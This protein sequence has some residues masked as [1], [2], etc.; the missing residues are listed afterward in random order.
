MAGLLNLST[1]S[2]PELLEQCLASLYHLENSENLTK[3]IILQTGN[4]QVSKLVDSFL[5]SRTQVIKVDGDGKSPLENINFNRWI[6]WKVGFEIFKADWILS[7]EEDVILHPKALTFVDAVY[8]KYHSNSRFRG[9]NLGSELTDYSLVGTYSILRFGLHGCGGVI[10]KKT[11]ENFDQSSL[12]RQIAEMPID[13]SIEANLKSGFMVTPNL[14]LYADFGWIGGTH[15][16]S[17]RSERH[18]NIYKSFKI[19]TFESGEYIELTSPHTWRHDCIPYRRLHDPL[20]SL[21]RFLCAVT[22]PNH[23]SQILTLGLFRFLTDI[24]KR[25]I[26]KTTKTTS[27]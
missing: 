12:I 13:S 23:V 7:I 11:W 21:A 20:Y 22:S 5:D 2:R 1:Y 25:F 4:D 3:L 10:T 19:N 9:I 16:S 8:E 17:T 14:S 26:E 18:L 27:S 6:S 24:I 15:T